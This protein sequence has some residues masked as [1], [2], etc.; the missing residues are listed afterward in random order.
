MTT[1]R[2]AC[3]PVRWFLIETG[4][5]QEIDAHLGTCTAAQWPQT[6]RPAKYPQFGP[7]EQ[8]TCVRAADVPEYVH[9]W[10]CPLNP[11]PQEAK[12]AGTV[13][14]PRRC[15]CPRVILDDGQ[16]W[17]VPVVHDPSCRHYRRRT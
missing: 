6:G 4:T 16:K 8:C 17:V 14:H 11:A 3:P 15:A 1:P 9:A 5:T 10:E 12:R 2:C 13:M 7:R